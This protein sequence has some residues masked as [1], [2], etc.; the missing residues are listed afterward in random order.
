MTNMSGIEFIHT[1]CG[2]MTFHQQL[3]AENSIKKGWFIGVGRAIGGKEYL[4]MIKIDGK[5][6][7]VIKPD[8]FTTPA[9]KEGRR[10]W[11]PEVQS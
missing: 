5:P 7:R 6:D 2:F 3:A 9:A 4:P 11:E 8:G 10:L 1:Y